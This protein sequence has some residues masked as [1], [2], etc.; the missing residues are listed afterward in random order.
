MDV[1]FVMDGPETVNA[2]T[3]TSFGLMLAAEGLG[4]RVWH[5]GDRDVGLIGGR[6]VATVRPA[7]L[8]D[9]STEPVRLGPPQEM[10]LHDTSAVFVRRDPP[11]DLDYL[12][13]T[14]LLDL[15]ADDTAVVN[16]PAG[17][18]TANEKLYITRFPDLIP[19]TIVTADPER[20]LAF[21]R[22]QGAAV[23]K[24][25][26]GHGGRGVLIVRPDDPN[27]PSIVDTQTRRGQQPVMAQAFLDAVTDGDKRILL[28]DGAPL[29]A[30][31]RRPTDQD[32]RANICVG[33]QVEAADIDDADRRI[34]DAL[35]P[36]LRADGL[37]FVGL[38]VIDGWLTEI[39]VTSP[40]G[41]R[42]LARL[43]RGDLARTVIADALG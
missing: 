27:A 2:G 33:G 29:G 39:N 18:R 10:S 8:A 32:F 22:A 11:F 15:A 26:D 43:D 40:T 19:P 4:H 13:L 14:Q 17:L 31:L 21:A 23:I 35:A 34:I 6:V 3:D 24:P 7:S 30:I 41:L 38:D 36:A 12:N 37:R 42:E 20:L 1:V 5:C 25:I 28:W 9:E 16:A